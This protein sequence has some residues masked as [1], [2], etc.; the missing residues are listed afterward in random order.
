MF[1][2]RITHITRP[3][4]LLSFTLNE[5]LNGNK[6]KPW[7]T[8]SLS[9]PSTSK[10]WE[11]SVH[12]R[13]KLIY[14]D[15][16]SKEVLYGSMV[17]KQFLSKDA[18]PYVNSVQIVSVNGVPAISAKNVRH[19]LS[20]CNTVVLH[21]MLRYS[22]YYTAETNLQVESTTKED[23]NSLK[24]TET[25]P[26]L[27]GSN[28]HVV[29]PP[30]A[31]KRVGRPKKMHAEVQVPVDNQK[32]HAQETKTVHNP[33]KNPENPNLPLHQNLQKRNPKASPL[34]LRLPP[35]IIL[36]L[37]EYV[38]KSP[39]R[40]RGPRRNIRRKVSVLLYDKK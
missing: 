27:Q 16:L 29:V 32:S 7:A 9:R 21:L 25:E 30:A 33:K 8:L 37:L 31:V 40:V 35:L 39:Q 22:Q 24:T 19:E 5:F 36:R 11:I 26:P 14:L 12:Q 6:V 4:T 10:P 23:V 15:P 18:F 20:R 34:I 28:V 13:K 38:R 2:T 3:L 1:S 17:A